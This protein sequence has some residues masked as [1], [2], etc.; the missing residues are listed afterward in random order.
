MIGRVVEG[1]PAT[2]RFLDRAAELIRHGDVSRA[3]QFLRVPEKTLEHWYYDWV[4]RQPQATSTP[5]LPITRIGIDELS[6]KKSTGS[7][8]R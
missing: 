1:T 8:S 7:S 3:A 2:E 6:L 4:E 5:A